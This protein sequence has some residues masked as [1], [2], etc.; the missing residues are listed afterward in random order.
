MASA[1]TGS[2]LNIGSAQT[3]KLVTATPVYRAT[4]VDFAAPPS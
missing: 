1:G 2:Y 4:T 3:G